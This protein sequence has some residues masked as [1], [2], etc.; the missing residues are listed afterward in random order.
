MALI[1]CPE[2]GKE[3]SSSAKSCPNCGHP[4]SP[5]TEKVVEKTVVKEKKKRGC[6]S[7]ILLFIVIIAVIGALASGGKD[8]KNESNSESSAPNQ[9]ATVTEAPKEY[10]PC[11]VNQM[12]QD[13][14]DNA[15][16]AS[17][18]YKDQYIEV[19]G[20]LGVIDSSGKYITLYPDDEYSL[21]GVQCYIKN[22]EQ[23]SAISK[24]KKN[25]TVTLKGKC[26]DVGEVLGY[27]LDIDSIN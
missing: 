10:T 15:M 20:R 2:C 24:M 3:V 25:D 18:K 5:S 14:D 7:T 27:S 6:L 23:K 4:I 12:I 1:K 22:D 9:K 8:S 26:K 13:L 21:I 17:D 16:G 11:T 19:T